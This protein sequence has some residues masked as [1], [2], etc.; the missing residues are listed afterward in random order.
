M[1]AN[2]TVTQENGSCSG[3][4]GMCES[5]NRDSFVTNNLKFGGEKGHRDAVDAV[6][7]NKKV[8]NEKR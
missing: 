5:C 3:L 2:A 1:V 6:R 7:Y 4:H 8:Q